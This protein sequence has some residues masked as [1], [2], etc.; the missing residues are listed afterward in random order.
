MLSQV[1][2][3]E[4]NFNCV[5]AS[6]LSYIPWLLQTVQFE[7]SL[8]EVGKNCDTPTDV[9]QSRFNELL[10]AFD[11]FSCICTVGSK[12]EAAVAAAAVTDSAVMEITRR[13]FR[14]RLERSYSHW[15]RLSDR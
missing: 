6:H 5:A 3:I 15:A 11:G 10:S 4:V 9:F 2:D 13:S 8:H 12:E 1:S 7:Y 14:R